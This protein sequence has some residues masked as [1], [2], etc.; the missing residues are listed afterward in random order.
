M[1]LDSI[2]SGSFDID[3][4][5]FSFD[6]GVELA[7]QRELLVKSLKLG[8][9]SHYVGVLNIDVLEEVPVKEVLKKK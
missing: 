1:M 6:G 9:N 4:N 3:G 8:L 7:S 2:E 5:E